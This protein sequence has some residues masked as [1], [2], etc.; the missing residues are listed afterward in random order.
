[1]QSL[2][3]EVDTLNPLTVDSQDGQQICNYI[4]ESLVTRDL[5]TG[6]LV[7]QLACSWEL[8][9][10]QMTYTF[11]LRKDVLWHDG[12]P[13]TADDVKFSFDR[14]MDEKDDTAYLRIYL[15][16]IKSCEV[17]DPYTVKFVANRKYFKTLESL[18]F[19]IAPK[20]GFGPGENFNTAGINR[21]PIGTGPF[22]FI[23]WKTGERIVLERNDHYWGMPYYL[24]RMVWQI[25]TNTSVTVRLVKR[26]DLD[27]ALVNALTWRR[28]LEG[29][30]AMDKLHQLLYDQPGYNYLGFN[31]KDP[32]FTDSRVRRAIDFLI[33]RQEILSTIYQGK[34]AT[35][36]SG[37]ESPADSGYD[38]SISPTPEDPAKARQLLSD[39]GWKLQD[40]GFLHKGDQRFEFD[41]MCPGAGSQPKLAELIQEALA[42]EGIKVDIDLMDRSTMYD[43][44]EDWK[45]QAMLGGW[46][47]SLDG[48][49]YQ[50]WHS[51]QAKIKKSSNFLRYESD[52]ADKL[53]EAIRADYDPA[54]RDRLNKQLHRIIYDDC[55]CCFLFQP[56]EISVASKRFQV[57][58][59]F[60]GHIEPSIWWVPKTLQRYTELGE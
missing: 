19:F 50:L 52:R 28:E 45:Y 43:T 10:D 5:F 1:M 20:H 51:S 33:P 59:T 48:D 42:K 13:F 12:V 22:R 3:S 34:Y 57:V 47:T 2:S 8:S 25:I 31:L 60:D 55:P 37:Y 7:P 15:D 14:I 29:R 9:P 54:D 23:E 41:L 21:K 30:P 49:P 40:D 53:I 58:P 46:A 18:G 36:V 11:H 32:L 44:A 38:H 16:M 56:K 35:P 6:K 27:L 26:G 39:A 4:Y 24:K 17:I